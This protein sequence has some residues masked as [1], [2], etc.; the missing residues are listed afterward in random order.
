MKEEVHRKL[1]AKHPGTEHLFEEIHINGKRF[2]RYKANFKLDKDRVLADVPEN[3][4]KTWLALGEA[5]YKSHG[6]KGLVNGVPVAAHNVSVAM[7]G[8]RF[9]KTE[10]E[11]ATDKLRERLK[12]LKFITQAPSPQ[13]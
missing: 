11:I 5:S 8:K 12:A 7:K 4:R 13:V 9:K 3:L 10:L 1:I 6:Q 2:F